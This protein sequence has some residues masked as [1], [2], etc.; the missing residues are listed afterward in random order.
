MIKYCG[1][2]LNKTGAR[3][4]KIKIMESSDVPLELKLEQCGGER[5]GGGIPR[6]PD[7]CCNSIAPRSEGLKAPVDDL[8]TVTL[9]G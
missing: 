1:M 8:S 4:M 3:V 5:C 9:A 6:P 7:T 2:Y